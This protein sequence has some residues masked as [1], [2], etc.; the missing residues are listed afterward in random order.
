MTMKVESNG[1]AGVVCSGSGLL[2]PV[3]A[4]G[5]QPF[6]SFRRDFTVWRWESQVAHAYGGSNWSAERVQEAN[7][8]AAANGLT[9][10]VASSPQFSPAVQI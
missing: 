10:F 6:C 5:R 8:Y 7:K 4:G 3:W 1:V 9:P 2:G